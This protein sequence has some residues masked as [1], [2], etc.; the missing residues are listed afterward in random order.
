LL[1]PHLN[2]NLFDTQVSEIGYVYFDKTGLFFDYD[3]NA[4]NDRRN[5]VDPNKKW[6]RWQKA[7]AG[8][9]LFGDIE[10]QCVLGTLMPSLHL[11]TS[12]M[13]SDL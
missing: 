12:N 4:R 3:E 7:D 1:V 2:E 10:D 9:R 6:F 13:L 8:Q 5:Q 11:F